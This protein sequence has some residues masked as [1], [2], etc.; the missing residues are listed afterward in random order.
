MIADWQK[1]RITAVV[2]MNAPIR[3]TLERTIMAKM[4]WQ[5]LPKGL[6]FDKAIAAT[7]DISSVAST[8]EPFHVNLSPKQMNLPEDGLTWVWLRIDTEATSSADEQDAPCFA[9]V[10]VI[11]G[12]RLRRFYEYYDSTKIPMVDA[13]LDDFDGA[14]ELLFMKLVSTYGVEPTAEMMARRA[15]MLAPGG[16]GPGGGSPGGGKGENRYLASLLGRSTLTLLQGTSF[17]RWKEWARKTADTRRV[18]TYMFSSSEKW[19]RSLYFEKLKVYTATR[20]SNRKINVSTTLAVKMEGLVSD[21][22][23]ENST[24]KAEL[25]NLRAQLEVYDKGN[26]RRLDLLYASSEGAVQQIKAQT[27]ELNEKDL[28]IQRLEMQ[29]LKVGSQY[30]QSTEARDAA[31]EHAAKAKL[32]LEQELEATRMRLKETELAYFQATALVDKLRPPDVPPQCVHCSHYFDLER[33]LA[34]A[35]ANEDYLRARWQAV[36][37]EKQGLQDRMN[38]WQAQD[39]SVRRSP[40]QPN[41]GAAGSSLGGGGPPHSQTLSAVAQTRPGPQSVNVNASF[42]SMSKTPELSSQSFA[43]GGPMSLGPNAADAFATPHPG[44]IGASNVSFDET[45]MIKQGQGT[46]PVP[47]APPRT[48]PLS[49]QGFFERE[50]AMGRERVMLS[51][52]RQTSRGVPSVGNTA[53]LVFNSSTSLPGGGNPYMPFQHGLTAAAPT[54][55]GSSSSYFAVSQRL[56]SG[57]AT[58]GGGSRHVDRSLASSYVVQEPKPAQWLSQGPFTTGAGGGRDGDRSSGGGEAGADASSAITSSSSYLTG[59][60]GVSHSAMQGNIHPRVVQE[61]LERKIAE[62]PTSRHYQGFSTTPAGS[63]LATPQE[64][65]RQLFG[66]TS[67][68][69]AGSW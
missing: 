22:A 13:V 48:N 29:L 54:V 52:D 9:P 6:R 1:R 7:R 21:V 35:R 65:R 5:E 2:P 50:E 66:S 68:T 10:R 19:M 14:E 61:V 53:A 34:V 24:L 28:Q 64:M 41:L 59:V 44:G 40:P 18:A 36:E 45:S 25:R 51:L 26:S 42:T 12:N 20:K 57:G 16:G 67:A 63:A 27:R 37:E 8:K 55:A 11:Y 31:V 38:Q 49:M 60:L 17:R 30:L 39:A 69:S 33:D 23:S 58:F 4:A 43:A 62:R 15:T 32:E 56:G 3:G 47:A 46:A